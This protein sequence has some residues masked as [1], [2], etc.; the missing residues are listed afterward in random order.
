[1]GCNSDLC[2]SNVGLEPTMKKKKRTYHE[3]TGKFKVKAILE[4][5][6]KEMHILFFFLEVSSFF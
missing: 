1:M 2:M 4:T 6:K 3:K 5:H